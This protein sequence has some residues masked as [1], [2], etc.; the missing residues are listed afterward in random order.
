MHTHTHTHTPLDERVHTTLWGCAMGPNV[1]AAFIGSPKTYLERE[2]ERKRE[3][4][5]CKKMR[6]EREKKMRRER[7]ER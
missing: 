4:K 3:K 7:D 2:R 5:V 1:V 6:R